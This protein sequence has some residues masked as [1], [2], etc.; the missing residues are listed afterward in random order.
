MNSIKYV[1]EYGKQS[2]WIKAV[3]GNK[4]LGAALK[5]ISSNFFFYLFI[6][7]MPG[8]CSFGISGNVGTGKL[9]EGSVTESVLLDLA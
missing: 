5:K 3:P 1:M 7:L 9:F 2:K 4:K 8:L 6:S